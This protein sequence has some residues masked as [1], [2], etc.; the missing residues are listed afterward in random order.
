[1]F[2]KTAG[3]FHKVKRGIDKVEIFNH[4]LL[5]NLAVQTKTFKHYEQQNLII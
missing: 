2:H 3:R 5:L 4:S 1:M